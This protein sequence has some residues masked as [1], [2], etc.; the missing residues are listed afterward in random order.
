MSRKK[1]KYKDEDAEDPD[2]IEE[3][4]QWIWSD[5]VIDDLPPQRS[6]EPYLTLH[7]SVRRDGLGNYRVGDIVQLEAD[8]SYYWIGLIRGFETDYGYKRGQRKRAIIIWFCRQND[9]LVKYQL[10]GAGIVY[11]SLN[12]GPI[13]IRQEE[14][15]ITGREDSV[16]VGC[17]VKLA[18]VYS[19]HFELN[20][21]RRTKKATNNPDVDAKYVCTRG[22]NDRNGQFIDVDWDSL[23]QH[24]DTDFDGLCGWVTEQLEIERKARLKR[25]RAEIVNILF[26]LH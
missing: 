3:E 17:I 16:S 24:E 21:C 4:N 19:S 18:T 11:S 10:K 20:K 2:E 26:G 25:K 6:T 14:I 12:K 13:L 15:Y 23:Y 5:G 8:K 22:V 7:N 1:S 9:L